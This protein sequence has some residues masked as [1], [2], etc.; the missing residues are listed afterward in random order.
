M[1]SEQSWTSS[2]FGGSED[3]KGLVLQVVIIIIM[4]SFT[5]ES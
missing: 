1:S 3:V 5:E 2:R 4:A